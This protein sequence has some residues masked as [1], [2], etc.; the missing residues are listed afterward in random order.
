[1]VVIHEFGHV[2]GFAHVSSPEDKSHTMLGGHPHG[3]DHGGKWRIDEDTFKGILDQKPD[4]SSGANLSIAKFRPLSSFSE[5]IWDGED[6]FLAD[7]WCIGDSYPQGMVG[8]EQD[9]GPTIHL[10]GT[11]TISGVDV[12]YFLKPVSDACGGSTSHEVARNTWTMSVNG[13]VR[14]EPIYTVPNGISPGTYRL[15]AMVDADEDVTETVENDN[16][17]TGDDDIVVRAATHPDCQ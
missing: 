10:T 15:C 4:S 12:T 2:F 1:M 11:Q 3:G 13:P 8:S 6:W 16:R 5:E 14:T 9:W 17:V 7:T